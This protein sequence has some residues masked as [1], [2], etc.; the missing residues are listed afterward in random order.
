[1][2]LK[3]RTGRQ[4]SGDRVEITAAMQN[5]GMELGA[6]WCPGRSTVGFVF[7]T[8]LNWDPDGKNW[9]EDDAEDRKMTTRVGLMAGV[10]SGRRVGRWNPY[11]V[12][13]LLSGAEIL[14]LLQR[15]GI[16]ENQYRYYYQYRFDEKAGTG[17]LISDDVDFRAK[18]T[19]KDKEWHSVT[20]DQAIR[21]TI[22]QQSIKIHPAKLTE[23]KGAADK[24]TSTAATS[25]LT[26]Q[27]RTGLLDRQSAGHRSETHSN[28][29][30]HTERPP[31][32]STTHNFL[33]HSWN[34]F[35]DRKYPGP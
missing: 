16:Q 26:S 2:H 21:K 29:L 11:Q 6:E 30:S 17:I 9:Q 24:S 28:R 15:E 23:L 35:I 31:N 3:K 7:T 34:K 4:G 8:D 1:M 13:K 19:T 22:K 27:Q 33:K 14:V 10:M 20:K 12:Q 18:K 5:T 25:T 32:N